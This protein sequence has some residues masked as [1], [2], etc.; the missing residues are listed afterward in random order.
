MEISEY[1]QISDDLRKLIEPLKRGES[2]T[3]RLTNAG[4]KQMAVDS[5]GNEVPVT[6]FPP[7]VNLT[8]E[9]TIFDPHL[10]ADVEIMAKQGTK[11]VGQG[12]N[13]EVVPVLAEIEFRDGLLT[14]TDKQV[15]I[16]EFLE[17]HP[18]NKTCVIPGHQSLT[19]YKFE[20]VQPAKDA[21]NEAKTVEQS[22][23]VMST[24]AT[25]DYETLKGVAKRLKL[26]TNTDRDSM[27]TS[28]VK[29]AQQDS[30]RVF[31][32]LADEAVQVEALI[33]NAEQEKVIEWEAAERRYVYTETRQRVLEIPSGN[34]QE[35]LLSY[36]LDNQGQTTRRQLQR[37]YDEKLAKKNKKK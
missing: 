3:Y 32:A 4:V 19:G 34:H 24:L 25:Y 8:A 11:T 29:L 17:L 37:V 33:A 27:F 16:Y 14:V 2:A 21:K 30:D 7:S 5:A 36:L 18:A 6:K 15:G 9:A 31:R 12:R 26:P 20:R 1:N 22:I 28:L 10:R 23:A 35:E 13:R